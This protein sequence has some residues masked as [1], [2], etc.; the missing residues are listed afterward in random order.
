[1][2]D[3]NSDSDS[4]GAQ[5]SSVRVS[6][7]AAAS[8]AKARQVCLRKMFSLAE[9]DEDPTLL[10]DLKEDVREECETLGKVTNVVLWDCE[11]EG[12]ITIKFGTHDAAVACVHK[13]NGRFFGGRQI[14]AHLL[15]GKPRFRRSGKGD[16]GQEDSDEE[17]HNDGGRNGTSRVS[18]KEESKRRDA[19]GEWLEGGGE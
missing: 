16:E 4:D 1:M 19:F 7:A 17:D 13:M 12:L 2:T 10:L 5:T 6:S 18:N 3:W 14:V 11:P 8:L 9:L 15:E